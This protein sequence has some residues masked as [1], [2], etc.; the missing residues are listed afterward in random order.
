MNVFHTFKKWLPTIDAPGQYFYVDGAKRG[1][2]AQ[3]IVA[4]QSLQF[5]LKPKRLHNGL[6]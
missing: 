6:S 4:L 5:K 1:L 2:T 3:N